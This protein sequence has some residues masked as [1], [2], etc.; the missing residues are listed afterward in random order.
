MDMV[1]GLQHGMAYGIEGM[2]VCVCK[3]MSTVTFLFFVSFL[4]FFRGYDID[5]GYSYK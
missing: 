1:N 4:L 3:W 2:F 5:L